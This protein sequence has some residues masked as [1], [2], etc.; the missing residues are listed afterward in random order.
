MTNINESMRWDDAIP[1][2]MRGDKVEG[3]RA[4]KP[5]LQAGVLANRTQYLRSEL[6]KYSGTLQAGEQPYS[7]EEDAQQA[8]NN[9]MIAAGAK[10][11]VR[12]HESGSWVD[13]YKNV[14]GIATPTGKK[15]PSL[16]AV[17]TLQEML[18]EKSSELMLFLFSDM[19][20]FH[21][22]DISFDEETGKPKFNIGRMALKRSQGAVFEV[23]DSDGF[24]ISGDDMI[25]RLRSLESGRYIYN[26]LKITRSEN[27]ILEVT[28][29][30]GFSLSIDDMLSRLMSI[31]KGSFNYSGQS[32][33]RSPDHI[34]EIKDP[35]G[36][37]LTAERLIERI[38]ALEKATGDS[39]DVSRSGEIIAHMEGEAQ[40]ARAAATEWVSP[41][42]APLRKGLNLFFI[43]GQSLAI[44]DEAFSVVTRQPS[45]LGNLMLGKSPRGRYYGRTSDADF[46]VIGGENIYY[47]LTEHRQDGPNIITDPDINTRL[48]ETVAS[49]FMETLKTLHNR[50]KGVKNDEETILACSVTGC[51]GTNI[52]TLLKGAGA[53][54]PYY[55][56]L[57]SALRGHME[58]A[59]KMGI[60]DVQVCGMLFL[61][62]ENDYG[63]TNRENYLNMLNQLINDFNADARAIT[64]QT[65]NIG[66]YLYQT[67]GTYVSQAEGNTLPID[68]AQ[69]D[70]TSRVDAFMAA[71]MFPYPQASNNRTHKAANSYRW[72]GCAAANTVFRVL[73]NENRTPFR[74]I[75]AVYDGEDIYVSFMTPCPPLATQPY[76]RIAAAVMNTDMGF[77]VIDGTGNLYGTSLVT[78]IISP[79]V[80]K[81][82][83][84][85]KLSGNI[86]LNLG[87]QLH[88]GGH[89]VADSSPQ[90]SFFNWQYYGDDNQSVNENIDALND[91]PYPLYNFAAIQTINVDGVE[92]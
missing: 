75:K 26:G 76:Y 52:A 12:S 57:M 4:A 1:M 31:E 13:E 69:L 85:R 72:W 62:G 9:G 38:T 5:N 45:Q 64:G 46:G 41:P 82:S 29:P 15:L 74:M 77:T 92:L 51:S 83:P 58:A 47:P 68:M 67:G 32:L 36:F 56:R 6:E 21:I 2:I 42:V 24:G 54:T 37:A 19:D 22:A 14:D 28:D 53:A 16:A 3:G 88:G 11:S 86:R 79:C 40:A 90:Q 33:Q 10:F 91:K 30:D 87:D 70:I 81:I 73:S 78:E 17:T 84:P 61:Q 18:S 71:P 65:D 49:G 43:Y 59:A 80:I 7:S 39:G 35:D 27:N 44:G 55:E 20:D 25:N 63:I 60:T 8:V 50:S 66:F 48:G 34:F 23:V 89:N